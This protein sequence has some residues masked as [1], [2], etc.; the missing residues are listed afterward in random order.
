MKCGMAHLNVFRPQSCYGKS[1]HLFA[2]LIFQGERYETTLR[3]CMVKLVKKKKKLT[4]CKV[5][6]LRPREG[7]T[8]EM[9]SSAV[10]NE[11]LIAARV[12]SPRYHLLNSKSPD[13]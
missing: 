7:R 13:R 9:T 8:D 1:H 11:Q 4:F 12:P 3:S 5:D 6:V 2:H 10:L